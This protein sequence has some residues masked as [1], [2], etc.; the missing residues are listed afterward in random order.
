MQFL[1]PLVTEWHGLVRE[2]SANN[3]LVVSSIRGVYVCY[4]DIIIGKLPASLNNTIDWGLFDGS[5]KLRAT[6]IYPRYFYVPAI[7]FNLVVRFS[8]V[9]LISPL[10]W[11]KR[12][13][14]PTLAL[15]LAFL[16]MARRFV[17]CLFRV[18]NEMV[19][20]IGQFR[21]VREVPLPIA[22]DNEE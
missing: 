18:E 17:W 19:T 1:G 3:D 8:W 7:I 14:V 4:W 12:E 22:L 20:N 13:E 6:L 5:K 2:G 9:L 21:A 11:L 15:V 10:G 16:E